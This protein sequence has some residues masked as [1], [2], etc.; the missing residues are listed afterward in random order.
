MA[1]KLLNSN[2][3]ATANRLDIA[4]S[5]APAAIGLSSTGANTYFQSAAKRSPRGCSGDI[6]NGVGTIVKH[7]A[8]TGNCSAL[9]TQT[10]GYPATPEGA[11]LAAN[12]YQNP[13][14]LAMSNIGYEN[15]GWFTEN[16]VAPLFK[17]NPSRAD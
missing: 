14:W 10:K 4:S 7:E 5:N 17:M 12:A 1:G 16:R 2:L 3:K 13:R 15:I 8:D 9:V 6:W 11:E